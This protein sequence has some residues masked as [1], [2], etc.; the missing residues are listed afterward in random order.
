[1]ATLNS[2]ENQHHA[3]IIYAHTPHPHAAAVSTPINHREAG[4]SR[5]IFSIAFLSCLRVITLQMAVW[6]T[7]AGSTRPASASRPSTKA[8]RSKVRS[9]QRRMPNSAPLRRHV[10]QWRQSRRARMRLGCRSPR[11]SLLK[12][13]ESSGIA[14]ATAPIGCQPCLVREPCRAAWFFR[15][16][17]D[18]CR[19]S[20]FF[21]AL[22]SLLAVGV[23]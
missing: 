22:Q 6:L 12:C 18:R 10:R 23:H 9:P 20:P 13:L 14:S 21:A 8:S 2:S 11:S 19:R 17:H 5:D 3:H 16:F 1:M 4:A 15:C 7:W